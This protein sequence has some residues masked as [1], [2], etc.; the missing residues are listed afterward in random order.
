L[1]GRAQ[2][3]DRRFRMRIQ[4]AYR[5]FDEVSHAQA[6]RLARLFG[7]DICDVHPSDPPPDGMYDAILYNLDEV[8]W[9]ERHAVV[10]EL[11][12]NSSPCPKA[13]HGYDLSE[14][15]A[16]Q[17]RLRGVAVA[18][19]LHIDLFRVLCR[20]V[21]RKLASVPPDDALVEET[22]INLAE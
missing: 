8:P 10:A 22:W 15:E 9:H 14:D 2:T 12:N 13:V 18:Q 4:I 5:N 7:A 17:L 20:T 19:R 3:L 6:A 16:A 21:V 1:V 11:L